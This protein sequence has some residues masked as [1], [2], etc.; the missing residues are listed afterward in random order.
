MRL[1]LA[2]PLAGS[3]ATE[4][5][6]LTARLRSTNANLRWAA[7]E[8]WH[9]TLQFLGST[10]EEQY[11]CLIGRV[12]E[13]RSAPVPVQLAEPG[14]FDRAG[15]FYAGV[16]LTP[17]LVALQQRVVAATAGCGFAAEARPY[18]PHITLARSKGRS[19]GRELRGL[20]DR[21]PAKTGFSRF[22]APEFLLY[23]SY[24]SSR[25]SQY[26]VRYRFPLTEAL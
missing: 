21:L 20:T 10:S 3:V 11:G 12:G 2:I 25:G 7:P 15:I 5:S 9:I 16:V 24:L 18:H 4:L 13:L 1:F 23:E 26:E 8:S 14:V 6:R 19:G 17:Q 22:M